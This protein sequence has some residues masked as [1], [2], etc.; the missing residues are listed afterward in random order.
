MKIEI[1][2]TAPGMKKVEVTLPVVK[3]RVDDLSYLQGIA[4]REGKGAYCTIPEGNKA[5]LLVL[6]LIEKVEIKP[7]GR[8]MEDFD[9]KRID[10]LKAI[11]AIIN[12][13]P[14]NWQAIARCDKHMGYPPQSTWTTHVTEAG[15]KL[16]KNGTA[17]VQ[18]RASCK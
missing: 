11:R 14:P 15:R 1:S 6:G 3:L 5:R 10:K 8:A 16:I 7:E 12:E 9:K 17:Q 13:E 2:T 4:N 18:V